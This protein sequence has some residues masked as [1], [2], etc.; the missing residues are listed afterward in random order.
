MSFIFEAGTSTASTTETLVHFS[1]ISRIVG[2]FATIFSLTLIFPILTAVWY[3][4]PEVGNFFLPMAGSL[5]IGVGLWLGA[6]RRRSY[7]LGNR[8]GF[9]IVALFWMLLSLLMV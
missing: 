3:N 2:L 9:I 1:S 8:D 7:D 5:A 4:E 6:G